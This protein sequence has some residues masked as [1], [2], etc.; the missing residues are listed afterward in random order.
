MQAQ[1]YIQK[2]FV[3][4]SHTYL[5]SVGTN[6]KWMVR[7]PINLPRWQPIK[8]GC[9]LQNNDSVP[10]CFSTKRMIPAIRVVQFMIR[11]RKTETCRTSPERHQSRL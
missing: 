8:I 7:K 4:T 1:N 3:G 9:I 10:N 5:F 2:T 11:N 6:R